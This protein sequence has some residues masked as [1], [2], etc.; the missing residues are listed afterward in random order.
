MRCPRRKRKAFWQKERER[1]R[2]REKVLSSVNRL[3][4]LK[5]AKIP[6]KI[7]KK[8]Q[9]HVPAHLFFNNFSL[10][11]VSF[12]FF[13]L[14]QRIRKCWKMRISLRKMRKVWSHCSPEGGIEE[15][16]NCKGR[17][18]NEAGSSG[19]QLP[20]LS[21]DLISLLPCA[22]KWQGYHTYEL[23]QGGRRGK[24]NGLGEKNQFFFLNIAML[25]TIALDRYRPR[26][27]GGGGEGFKNTQKCA[28]NAQKMRCSRLYRRINGF[29]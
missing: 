8:A 13:L 6:V 3:S 1:E 12:F 20:F 26:V 17:G 23:Q 4:R 16:C 15:G 10:V 25:K 7:R 28:K 21:S 14:L 2:E 18:K 19:L 5:C 27:G 9:K 24:S 29:F 22:V 11:D